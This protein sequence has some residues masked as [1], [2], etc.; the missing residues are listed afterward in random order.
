[1]NMSSD[2]MN[3]LKP[4]AAQTSILTTASVDAGWDG[5]WWYGLGAVWSEHL[6]N[7]FKALLKIIL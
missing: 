3:G 4:Y 1:M 6:I 5:E 2:H 7:R